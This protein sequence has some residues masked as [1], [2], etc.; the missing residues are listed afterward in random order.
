LLGGDPFPSRI[1]ALLVPGD[2]GVSRLPDLAARLGLEAI[3]LTVPFV[4]V[5]STVTRPATRPPMVLARTAN[6]L[7]RQ[8]TDSARVTLGAVAPGEGL[9]ELVPKAFG[10]KPALVV[11]GA[12]SAGATRALEQVAL[13]FPHLS[14][15]G[16][17]R[18]TLDV[19]EQELW[20]ALAGYAP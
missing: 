2:S 13:T 11:T 12:D 20:D 3:G 9:I 19:V 16:K 1:D 7:T 8:L 17:D 6:P 4:E 18:P 5:A 15:R 10:D 14:E